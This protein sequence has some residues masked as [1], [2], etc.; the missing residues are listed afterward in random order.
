MEQGFEAV[1]ALGEASAAPALLQR[2]SV[3]VGVSDGNVLARR[4]AFKQ[5]RLRSTMRLLTSDALQQIQSIPLRNSMAP[6]A[7]LCSAAWVRPAGV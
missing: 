7:P 1:I 2:Q 5:A 6:G 3:V 4:P